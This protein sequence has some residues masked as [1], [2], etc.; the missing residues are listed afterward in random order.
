MYTTFL[1]IV[2]YFSK[3]SDGAYTA[4]ESIVAQDEIAAVC[5]TNPLIAGYLRQFLHSCKKMVTRMKSTIT[6]AQQVTTDEDQQVAKRPRIQDM[7]L[8]ARLDRLPTAVAALEV[9]LNQK[10]SSL[11]SS[12]RISTSKAQ[13]IVKDAF[14]SSNI[15]SAV[16]SALQADEEGGDVA[17]T[18]DKLYT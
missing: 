13:N 16:A 3:S 4:T 2:L 9:K 7:A 5:M 14:R 11:A 8:E 6:K 10:V 1:Q 17:R 15:F 18:L 12:S